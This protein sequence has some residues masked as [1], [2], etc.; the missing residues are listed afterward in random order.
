[1]SMATVFSS[2]YIFT[3]PYL[4]ISIILLIFQYP[5]RNGSIIFAAPVILSMLT[6][7]IQSTKWIGYL[8]PMLDYFDY[9][10]FHEITNAQMIEHNKKKGAKKCIIALQPHGVISFCG[11]CAMVNAPEELRHA[12]TAAASAVMKVPILKNVMGIFGLTDASAS[13]LRKQFR[14]EGIKGS[15]CIYIGGIAELFLSSRKVEKLYLSKRKGFIK[16]ALREGVDIIP[17]YLFGNTSVLTVLKG[18]PLAQLSRKL[19]ASVT[20]FWG[21]YYLPIPRNE[22]LVYARGPMMGLPHIPN[23]TNEDINKWHAKYCEEVNRLF[24]TYK[25]KVPMYKNKT[26]QIE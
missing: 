21:A 10:E 9:E 17:V 16:L 3:P 22:K 8:A 20:Y 7:P 15:V 1:M 19:Q 12:K 26:L 4:L 25:E 5:T 11:M 24:E 18:G 23:P 14:N 2:T 6:S 13:N